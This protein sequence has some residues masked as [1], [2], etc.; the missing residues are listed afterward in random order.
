MPIFV[1]T[2]S[3][4]PNNTPQQLTFAFDI[5]KTPQRPKKWLWILFKHVAWK[6]G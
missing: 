2:S 6:N 5:N 1:E 3:K 4:K